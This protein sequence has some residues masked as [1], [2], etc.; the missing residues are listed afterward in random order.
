MVV[1]MQDSWSGGGLPDADLSRCPQ[2]I[3]ILGSLIL[4]QITVPRL[5]TRSG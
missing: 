3:I 1:P 4:N 2:F 5:W